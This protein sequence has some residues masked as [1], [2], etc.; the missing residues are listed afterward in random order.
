MHGNQRY[1]A[2]APNLIYANQRPLCRHQSSC[3]LPEL[4][5]MCINVRISKYDSFV[6]E[7][8]L[9]NFNPTYARIRF[10]NGREETVS[11]QKLPLASTDGNLSS[12]Q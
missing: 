10:Q 9:A 12:I 2:Q 5:F 3:L 1:I 7:M 11:N 8:E 6:D 4:I